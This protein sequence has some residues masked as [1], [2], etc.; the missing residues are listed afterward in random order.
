MPLSNII[1]I[2]QL[3]VISEQ[4]DR[5]SLSLNSDIT[6]KYYRL[7]KIGEQDIELIPGEKVPLTGHVAVGG[8]KRQEEKEKLS[9][10]IVIQ[11]AKSE[12]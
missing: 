8:G 6:L 5:G 12:E 4:D 11:S 10:I 1:F 7:Q 3:R 2:L 9:T